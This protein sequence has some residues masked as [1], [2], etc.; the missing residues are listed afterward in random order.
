M[1]SYPQSEIGTL[2]AQSEV[3]YAATLR[4]FHGWMP[5]AGI[6]GNLATAHNWRFL[7]LLL[8]LS[9]VFLFGDDRGYFYRSGYHNSL[10]SN[11]MTVAANRSLE[12]NLLG[13][14]RQ[15]PNDDVLAT[16][17]PYNRFPIG[18]SLLIT[19]VILPFDDDLSAQI[20]AARM[21]MLTFFAGAAVLAFLAFSRLTSNDWIALTVT[22]LTFH[23]RIGFITTM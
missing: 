11:N 14:H 19:L 2:S 7:P 12:H 1:N 17:A 6:A 21:L 10:S 13:F 8:A 15:I 16:Y 22:L 4:P 18:G 20:Y 5:S 23:P 3:D 9:T